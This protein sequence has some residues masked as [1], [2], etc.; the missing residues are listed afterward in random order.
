MIDFNNLW[1]RFDDAYGDAI[2]EGE[3]HDGAC[4]VGIQT[5]L[6]MLDPMLT[7]AKA[8]DLRAIHREAFLANMA[9]GNTVESALEN[10]LEAIRQWPAA[11]AERDRMIEEMEGGAGW[12]E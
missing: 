9:C 6:G 12:A 4:K 7:S 3:D 8:Q 5:V 1:C 2:G 11:C 10:A